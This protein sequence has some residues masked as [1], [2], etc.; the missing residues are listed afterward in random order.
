MKIEIQMRA[1][2]FISTLTKVCL[3]KPRTHLEENKQIYQPTY[4]FMR[5]NVEKFPLSV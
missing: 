2:P 3:M 5:Y 1:L 4:N